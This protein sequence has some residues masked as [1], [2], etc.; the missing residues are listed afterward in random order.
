MAMTLSLTPQESDVLRRLAAESCNAEDVK[1]A[2]GRCPGAPLW[3]RVVPNVYDMDS[4]TDKLLQS[5]GLV[6]PHLPSSFLLRLMEQAW[7]VDKVR[8]V[9]SRKLP[10]LV[11][12]PR[13]VAERVDPLTAAL[14]AMPSQLPNLAGG[15]EA[16]DLFERLCRGRKDI[17][18]IVNSL[19]LFAALKEIH[20]AL[21]TLQVLGGDWL[22]LLGRPGK[23][24][25]SVG[26]LLA[27]LARVTV[28]TT[29]LEARLPVDVV[30]SCTRCREASADADRRIRNGNPD[31]MAFACAS[32]RAILIRE[33]PVI[34]AAMF[35][36]SRDFPLAQF[37]A[38][39]EDTGAHE[40]AF[41]LGD[42]LRR[43]LMQ[44]TLWQATDQSL[45]QIEQILVAPNDNWMGELHTCLP[46]TNLYLN[47]LF[48]EP[49]RDRVVG[50]MRY[51]LERF[52]L[53]D[54]GSVPNGIAKPTVADICA[55]FADLR[56]AARS[57]FLDVDRTLRED[58][59]LLLRLKEPFT[60]ILSRVPVN[61]EFLLL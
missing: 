55:V 18:Q 20:D 39:F 37:C 28:A 22:N 46:W 58:F 44:H 26:V 52:V 14:A 54:G 1:K 21:H 16:N 6:S 43:R 9:V 11:R 49:T 31:D 15:F 13:G 51:V 10:F 2:L 53:G 42:T 60:T 32:L 30:E 50:P 57:A 41:D 34:D 36:V 56:N 23:E 3:D 61:C 7:A 59:S 19:T 35:A 48:D 17:E 29:E 25:E 5:V 45:Y 47:A 38:L 12:P 8:R 27:L 24:P 40:A 4:L 33:P